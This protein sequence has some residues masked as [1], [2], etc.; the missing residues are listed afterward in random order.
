MKLSTM[1]IQ[2]ECGETGLWLI[3]NLGTVRAIRRLDSH[4][5]KGS[6]CR[7]SILQRNNRKNSPIIR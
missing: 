4:V 3:G 7:L 2:R 6:L 1:Q 5:G